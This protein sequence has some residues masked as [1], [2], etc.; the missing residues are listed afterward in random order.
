MA[1]V[2]RRVG[3]SDS[4]VFVGRGWSQQDIADIILLSEDGDNDIEYHVTWDDEE[5]EEIHLNR[6]Q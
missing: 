3:S 5:E 1:N 4:W 2:Y 6:E